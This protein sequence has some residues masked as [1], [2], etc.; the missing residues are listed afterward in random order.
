[1]P[2]DRRAL[3]KDK[4]DFAQVRHEQRKQDRKELRAFLRMKSGYLLASFAAYALLYSTASAL[5]ECMATINGPNGVTLVGYF[6]NGDGKEITTTVKTGERFIAA[7]PYDQ[8]EKAW[9]VYL[10]SGITGRIDR[11]R[12]G[13]LPDE[14]L[15]KLNYGDSKRGWRKAKSKQVTENDEAAW[16]AKQHGVNYYDTLIRASE[17]DLKAMARFDSLAEFMDGAAGESYHPEWWALFHVMGGENFARYLKSR[18]AKTREGYKG[19]FS[20]VGIEGFDPIWNPKPYIK[21]NFPKTYKI[22][23]SKGQ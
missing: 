19:I 11:D 22:L 2:H 3:R 8:S 5:D 10:K 17:G 14:P 6:P 15:M 12:L 18:P 1:M 7:P 13:L 20:T 9:R 16:Q 23:F 4:E 21:Q